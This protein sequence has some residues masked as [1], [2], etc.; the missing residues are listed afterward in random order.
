MIKKE[1]TGNKLFVHLQNFMLDMVFEVLYHRIGLFMKE[2]YSF[3][4]I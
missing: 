2:K 3:S 4:V 1:T